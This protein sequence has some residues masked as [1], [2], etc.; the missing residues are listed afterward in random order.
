MCP[1]YK[2]RSKMFEN[3][4]KNIV[5]YEIFKLFHLSY[6]LLGTGNNELLGIRCCGNS[7]PAKKVFG[8]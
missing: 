2:K 3:P 6:H 8:F 4:P 5:H 1:D 7:A